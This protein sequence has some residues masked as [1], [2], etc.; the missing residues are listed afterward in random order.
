M[1]YD[2]TKLLEQ[3][4]AE[5]AKLPADA[6]DALAAAILHEVASEERWAEAFAQHPDALAALADEALRELHAGA[7]EPLDPDQ[8]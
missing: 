5:A 3:A 8:P 4:F 7:T 6:Q 2:M 1:L